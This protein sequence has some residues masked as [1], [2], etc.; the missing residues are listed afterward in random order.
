MNM[1]IDIEEF[2]HLFQEKVWPWGPM[3]VVF[4]LW[5]ELPPANLISNVNIVP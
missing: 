3:R 1:G 2:P 4:E 5:D